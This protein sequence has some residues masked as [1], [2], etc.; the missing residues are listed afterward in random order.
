M[1]CTQTQ[2]ATSKMKCNFA[3]CTFCGTPLRRTILLGG[4]LVACAESRN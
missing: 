4:V 3:E 1:Y 2:F